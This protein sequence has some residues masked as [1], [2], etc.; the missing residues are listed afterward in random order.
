MEKKNEQTQPGNLSFMG[1]AVEEDTGKSQ[2]LPMDPEETKGDGNCRSQSL[3]S[4]EKEENR[5]ENDV[6]P[7]HSEGD[8]PDLQEFLRDNGPERVTIQ[9][10]PEE[11]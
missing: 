6:E 1:R 10:R 4:E 5:M 11:G 7:L 2:P 8:E 3:S 9:D